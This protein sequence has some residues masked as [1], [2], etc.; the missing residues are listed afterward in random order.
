MNAHAARITNRLALSLG[1]LL[2]ALLFVPGA[3][4]QDAAAL[5]ARHAALRDALASNAFQ[6]PLVLESTESNGN[7]TGEVY[8]VIAQP[9]SVV[10]PAM[11]GTDHWCDILIVHLNVK[12]CTAHAS[13][14]QSVLSL[15]VGRKYDQPLAD[16]YRVDFA[17]R[18]GASS[19]DYLKVMLSAEAGPLGTKDYRIAIEATPIGEKTSFVHMSYSYGYGVA[20]RLAMQGYLATIGR[21]K[22]GFTV[23]GRELDGA[24]V[25]IGNV[26]GLVERNTMRYY[27]AVEAYLGAYALP[28]AQQDEKR[29][30][31]WFSAVERYPR[32]LHEMER[33][34][35]L[36][37]KRGSRRRSARC[38]CAAA[39]TA[40]DSFASI[41]GGRAR[42]HRSPRPRRVH[43]VHDTFMPRRRPT[44][45]PR[46][47]L[48]HRPTRDSRCAVRCRRMPAAGQRR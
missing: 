43:R 16:A 17:Y 7:L 9:Y 35:Y 32:Q 22:V 3:H 39:E 42:A 44:A 8:A 13:G 11:Q 27:L 4:A 19:A 48:V 24:P 40:R 25:Y 41:G 18:V 21:N 2:G 5:R 37:M 20:A 45:R 38:R 34:E 36:A 14:E 26:R 33:E 46:A 23:V 12:R 30:N 31:D 47:R 10:G 28:A 15:A 1:L 29:L 6:R